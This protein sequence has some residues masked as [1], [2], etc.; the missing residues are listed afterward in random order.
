MISASSACAALSIV[1][2][3]ESMFTVTGRVTPG[4]A[5]DQV[6]A[7]FGLA[8]SGD[9]VFRSILMVVEAVA[10]VPDLKT[11]YFSVSVALA[12]PVVLVMSSTS[13]DV[14]YEAL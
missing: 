4:R 2:L 11:E 7:M 14:S 10:V 1:L 8:V 5:I 9:D 12:V 3:V 6:L 13:V